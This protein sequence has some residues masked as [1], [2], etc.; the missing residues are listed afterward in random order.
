[1]KQIES[2]KI[3]RVE[4]QGKPLMQMYFTF[5]PISKFSPLPGYIEGME[6]LQEKE[7]EKLLHLIPAACRAIENCICA[8]YEHLVPNL[9][10]GQKPFSI[11]HVEMNNKA[12]GSMLIAA[13]NVHDKLQSYHPVIDKLFIEGMK[14][15]KE[16]I[17]D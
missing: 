11:H 10:A 1:M 13:C 17:F 5:K 12:K 6:R 16:Q 8:M 14:A 4:K 7:R 2:I 15:L 3:E 9:P